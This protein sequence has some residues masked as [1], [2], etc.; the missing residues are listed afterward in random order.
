MPVDVFVGLV[1]FLIAAIPA[2]HQTAAA[3]PHPLTGSW[4]ANI[5]KSQR[6]P[7]HQF[8][9]ATMRFE[10]AGETVTIVYGGINAR[11][12]EES[13]RQVLQAD[14]KEHA[15]AEAPGVFGIAALLPR[16]LRT[17]GKKDDVVIGRATYA[18]APD[19]RSM[20]ATVSG[21]AADGKSFDQVI[22]FDRE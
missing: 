13:G 20:T 4:V 21:L 11:G 2:V 10:I 1:P 15:V 6:D 14:G 18:V 3:A 12:R 16:E 9:R 7:N 5:E 8:S 19:G 22:V 17:W